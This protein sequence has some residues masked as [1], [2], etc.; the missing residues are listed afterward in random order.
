MSASIQFLPATPLAVLYVDN[1]T[2]IVSIRQSLLH[3]C[4]HV[5][6][7]RT[8]LLTTRSLCS[9]YVYIN[10]LATRREMWRPTLNEPFS[11]TNKISVV[12]DSLKYFSAVLIGPNVL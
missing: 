5:E 9:L 8:G 7:V 6:Y 2:C 11:R 4:K 1:Q 3:V 10:I 12:S